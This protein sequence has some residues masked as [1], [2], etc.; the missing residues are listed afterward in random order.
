MFIYV[1]NVYVNKYI[2]Q[3]IQNNQL[4]AILFMFKSS[5][6]KLMLPSG[7]PSG[8]YTKYLYYHYDIK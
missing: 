5:G 1:K 6:Y 4:Q 2:N 3:F 8:K 7:G